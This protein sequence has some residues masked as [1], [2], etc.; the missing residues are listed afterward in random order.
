MGLV[1]ALA[2]SWVALLPTPCP[3]IQSNPGLSALRLEGRVVCTP[4]DREEGCQAEGEEEEEA[5][6][7]G[8]AGKDERGCG[9]SVSLRR[10][11]DCFRP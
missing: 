8:D 5:A 7:D 3:H 2:T 10:A 6:E 1:C 9:L 4:G 11:K